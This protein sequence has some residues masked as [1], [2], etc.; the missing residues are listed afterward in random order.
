[1]RLILAA[2]V[3]TVVGVLYYHPLRAFVETRAQLA[4]R[5]AE[6]RELRAERRSLERRLAAQTSTAALVREARR[7]GYVRPGERVF[8][9]KGIPEWRRAK[10]AA[11][12]ARARKRATIAGDG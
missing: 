7:L 11:R 2:V 8:V 5:A 3:L 4:A 1:M 9:V 6:V 10:A 12:T